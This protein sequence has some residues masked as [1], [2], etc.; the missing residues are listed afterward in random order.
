LSAGINRLNALLAGILLKVVRVG[1]ELPGGHWAAANPFLKQPDFV[2]LDTGNG[3]AL[4]LDLPGKPWL[5]DC[6]SEAQFETLLLPALR[7]YGL[8]RLEGLA[9]SHG[10]AAHIGG[11]F[12]TQ[13]LL[14]PR[15]F[16][17]SASRD[18]SPTRRRLGATPVSG[19]GP[20]RAVAAGDCLQSPPLPTVEVLFPPRGLSASLADDKCLA[21]RF[22]S[23]GWS[24]LYTADSGYPTERWLLEHCPD[25]LAAD[26]WVR[27]NH[28]REVT[29][30]EA[31]VQAVNPRLIVVAGAPDSRDARVLG[32]WAGEWRARGRQV[33][34]QQDAGAVEGWMGKTQEVRG[35]LNRQ[36]LSW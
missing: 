3:A 30:T 5:F 29:G 11:A 10:D 35:Y 8:D 23:S 16:V 6:G 15:H 28:I 18:R 32:R 22:R 14:R 20:L 13:Q 19:G 25:M 4:L 1:A 33:W 2:L 12:K 27:G 34:L 17:D 7:N 24:L 9:L 26:I 36:K 31:F 21:V